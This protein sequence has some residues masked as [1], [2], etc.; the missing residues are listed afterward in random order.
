VGFFQGGDHK[1]LAYLI[2]AAFHHGD[3]VF[4]A[5]HYNFKGRSFYLLVA[6][7][8]DKF[9]VHLADAGARNRAVKRNIGNMY[10]RRGGDNR[11]NIR[12]IHL[13]G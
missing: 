5:G 6:W 11:Q 2:G 1:I 3:P 7:V 4:G 9:P 13:I 10:R 12:G 8:Q